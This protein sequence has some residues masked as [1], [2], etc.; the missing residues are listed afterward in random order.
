M[1]VPQLYSLMHSKFKG[2]TD[3]PLDKIYP[4]VADEFDEE[5]FDSEYDISEFF[6]KD[7]LL[8]I[9]SIFKI[10]GCDEKA[11]WLQKKANEKPVE[12]E[13]TSKIA[14]Y[15][16]DDRVENEIQLLSQ[17]KR[18]NLKQTIDS[19]TANPEL[20]QG[21]H[22]NIGFVIQGEILR[23]IKKHGKDGYRVYF[24]LMPNGTDCIILG[25]SKGK[26]TTDVPQNEIDSFLS[27]AKKVQSSID[28]TSLKRVNIF[29]ESYVGLYGDA[30]KLE[31]GPMVDLPENSGHILIAANRFLNE[32]G[33]S[34]LRIVFFDPSLKVMELWDQKEKLGDSIEFSQWLFKRIFGENCDLNQLQNFDG[35]VIN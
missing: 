6:S 30:E 24:V 7:E 25:L 18:K 12:V 28:V 15:W 20:L 22:S 9:S 31:N 19:V 29:D 11:E 17:S 3:F 35:Y 2:K 8:K 5:Y 26:S 16:I 10:H 33:E 32:S 1:N 23:A 27:L 13:N 34:S 4:M 14:F 21:N